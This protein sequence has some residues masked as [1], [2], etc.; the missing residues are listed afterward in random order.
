MRTRVPAVAK[1]ILLIWGAVSLVG[2]LSIGAVVAY[3]F[4]FGNRDKDDSASP[5]DVRFVLNWC[6]LGDSRIE[7]V[8]HSHVSARSLTGDHLD[9]YA[10][11]ISHINVGELTT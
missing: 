11:K 3:Q 6:R 8:V 9:V 4:R 5:R 2:V 7:Q 1:W 10:I